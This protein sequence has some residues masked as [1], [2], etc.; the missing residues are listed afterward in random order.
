V[1]KTCMLSRGSFTTKC[2]VPGQYIYLLSGQLSTTTTEYHDSTTA[3]KQ[4]ILKHAPEIR[5]KREKEILQQFEG[6]ACIRQLIDHGKD[7]PFLVLEHLDSDALRFSRQTQIS[8]QDIKLIAHSI[9]SALGSLHAKGIAHTG[10]T[11][12]SYTATQ[13][14]HILIIHVSRYQTG[15]HTPKPRPKGFEGRGSQVGGL[16]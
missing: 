13:K 1:R 11:T 14:P 7:S 6:D 12:R 16:W 9:L 10:N 15:Q 2:G 8:R 4:V 5:L 3:H